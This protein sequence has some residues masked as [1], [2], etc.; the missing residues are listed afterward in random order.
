VFLRKLFAAAPHDHRPGHLRGQTLSEF[1]PCTCGAVAG[2]AD[3]PAIHST[4]RGRQPG[5]ALANRGTSPASAY[6]GVAAALAT[7]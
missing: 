1:E 3:P 6:E 4:R 5:H 7:S 2:A